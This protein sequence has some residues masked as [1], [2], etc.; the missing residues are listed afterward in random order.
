MNLD[1]HVHGIL[2]KK[3]KFDPD[4]FIQGIEYAKE[5][6]LD[7]YIL[8]EHFNAVDLNSTFSYLKDNFNYEGDRYIVNGFSIFLGMEVDIKDSGH[9][10]VTGNRDSI[11]KIR[12]KLEPHIKRANFIKFEDLLNLGEK[13]NCLMIGSHPYRENHKLYIQPEHLLRRLHGLD[14][15]S[16]DIYK[17]GR[18]IVELEVALLSKK[19]DISYVTG[20]DS[21]HPIQLGT[22]RTCFYNECSTIKELK[23][24]IKNH[25]YTIE[26]SNTLNLRV[27]SAKVTK[28]NM[29]KKIKQDRINEFNECVKDK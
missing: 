11:V 3:L 27:F 8:C 19:L 18:E 29:K 17:R 14:L 2:S 13:Y 20:S 5:N 9:I 25:E 22:I 4:L 15:N 28:N 7:G 10:I 1:F 23:E 24:A 16:K 12:E 21:H 6:S 26:V